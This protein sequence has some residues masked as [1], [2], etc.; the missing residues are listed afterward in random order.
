MLHVLLLLVC[1]HSLNSSTERPFTHNLYC[2][3]SL[4]S[5]KTNPEQKHDH[6]NKTQTNEAQVRHWEC[7]S[8][9]IG[10][11]FVGNV[12]L[13]LFISK[14]LIKKNLSKS[15]NSSN[16]TLYYHSSLCYDAYLLQDFYFFSPDCDRT[17][18]F[19][20]LTSHCFMQASSGFSPFKC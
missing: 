8:W 12:F 9:L 6:I 16:K 2:K 18:F 17:G 7:V 4:Q 11:L 10:A 14:H 13:F 5:Q 19:L 20:T 3:T 1:G 15:V